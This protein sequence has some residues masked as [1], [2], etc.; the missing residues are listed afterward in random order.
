MPKHLISRLAGKFA[1]A[2]CGRVTT[3]AIE[4]FIKHYGINM[5]EAKLKNAEDFTT[6][7][8]FFT[9]EL[10]DGARPINNDEA[11][12]CYPV[13]GAISQ[14]GDITD[15]RLIQAKG[16]DYSLETLLGGSYNTAK[17]FQ[18]GKFSCIYLAPKD[19]HRIH[20]PMA[21]TLREMIFVPG[22]LFSVNPLTANNVPNLFS[23]NERVVAIFDTNSGPLAMVLVGATIVASIETTWAGTITS[24]RKKGIFRESYPADGADAI[25][26]E[27]GDEMGRFKLGSTVVSTFAPGMIEFTVDAHAGTVTRLGELYANIVNAD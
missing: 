1:A 4:A 25:T 3:K 17:P 10:E 9:R 2:Q 22:D 18:G 26:F 14:Q 21:A 23:R 16:F 13:D 6:F 19:Y 5:S 8:D 20:M 11:T 27:K 15:G 12:L 7:N 24:P